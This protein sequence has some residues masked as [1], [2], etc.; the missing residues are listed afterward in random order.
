M[1]EEPGSKRVKTDDGA[2]LESLC[3]VINE[4]ARPIVNIYLASTCSFEQCDFGELRVY[5]DRQSLITALIRTSKKLIGHLSLAGYLWSGGEFGMIDDLTDFAA[6]VAANTT[7]TSLR[8]TTFEFANP[9]VLFAALAVNQCLKSVDFQLCKI[10]DVSALVEALRANPAIEHVWLG[11]NRITDVSGF[12]QLK[13]LR[14]LILVG[15]PIS[16]DDLSLLK[17]T[18]SDTAFKR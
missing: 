16:N 3:S 8:L 15:N 12:M 7:I 17:S 2:F 13:H 10:S 9:D 11:S 6:A 5:L 1:M 4:K 14:R 18:L